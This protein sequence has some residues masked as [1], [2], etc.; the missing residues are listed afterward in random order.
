VRMAAM[1]SSRNLC[2]VGCCLFGM[3]PCHHCALLGSSDLRRCPLREQR[4]HRLILACEQMPTGG[5]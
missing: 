4:V 3:A 1:S 2:S 5:Y